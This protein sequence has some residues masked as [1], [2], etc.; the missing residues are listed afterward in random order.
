M[1]SKDIY[2]DMNPDKSNGV[3]PWL[4]GG[5]IGMAML[6]V[7]A[8]IYGASGGLMMAVI[9]SALAIVG[10]LAEKSKR[11]II[12]AAA[13]PI[14]LL[15]ALVTSNQGFLSLALYPAILL[16]PLVHFKRAENV[17]AWRYWAGVALF[18][19][20]GALLFWTFVSSARGNSFMTF[21]SISVVLMIVSAYFTNPNLPEITRND[22]YV[23]GAAGFFGFF[24]LVSY[25]LVPDLSGL[26]I[27][28]TVLILGVIVFFIVVLM[29]KYYVNRLTGKS[30]D[31]QGEAGTVRGTKIER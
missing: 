20:A 18:S 28:A 26:L 24:A 13:F 21:Q 15:L 5:A 27:G 4:Q 17:L 1:S 9:P 2:E 29:L 12:L 31:Q 14:G 30:G 6:M 22:K 25:W 10:W 16:S 3:T 7:A 23:F 19:I 11:L 8:A